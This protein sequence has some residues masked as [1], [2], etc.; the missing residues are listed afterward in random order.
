[1]I[2]NPYRFISFQVLGISFACKINSPFRNT[3]YIYGYFHTQNNN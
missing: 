3:I 2:C 1:M